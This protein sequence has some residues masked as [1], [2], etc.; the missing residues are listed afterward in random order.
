MIITD[1]LGWRRRI[2][3]DQSQDAARKERK[4]EREKRIGG[5][6]EVAS[7]VVDRGNGNLERV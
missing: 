3:A 4:S 2:V 1:Q 7:R 6:S 5:G